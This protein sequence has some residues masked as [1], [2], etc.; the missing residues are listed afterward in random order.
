[1]KDFFKNKKVLIGIASV[2]I[3]AILIVGSIFL[4]KDNKKDN[5]E[6]KQE[7]TNNYVAYI[8]I[9][10]LIK[11]EFSQTCINTN[12][13]DNVNTNCDNPIVTKYELVNDDAK[14]IYKDVNLIDITNQLWSVLDLIN[15]T[16]KEHDINFDTVDIYSDWDK[17]EQYINGK[18]NTTYNWK[19][20]ITIK[21]TTEL[22]DVVNSLENEIQSY[23]VTFNTDGGN[24]I[25]KQV[26]LKGEK[27]KEPTTPTKK[28]YIF[29][30]WQV[31]GKKFDYNT[32]ITKDLELKAIWKK[33]VSS[34]NNKPNN[35]N[36]NSNQN[37]HNTNNPNENNTPSDTPN[38]PTP[39]PENIT[40]FDIPWEIINNGTYQQFAKEHGITINLVADSQYK[41][42]SHFSAPSNPKGYKKGDVVIA[43]GFMK[44]DYNV[45]LEEV[46]MCDGENGR[47]NCTGNECS[48]EEKNTC[49]KNGC[50]KYKT[51]FA[52]G[53]CGE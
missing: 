5:K 23:N 53:A 27:I 46:Y 14:T 8:K 29:V 50:N 26:V 28:G 21:S 32:I 37:N 10:P 13:N 2:L 51:Y 9:N 11:L 42:T 4:F 22:N 52:F 35:S 16:A 40:Y 48:E 3:L 36:N 34:N 17:L 44:E 19:Y 7:T 38:N 43:Y 39:P 41:C 20:N 45:C 47:Y 18:N 1:M 31:D 12:I 6:N 15:N 30:E 25:T 49:W 33:E 24:T